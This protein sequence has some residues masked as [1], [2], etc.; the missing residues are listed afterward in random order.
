MTE[1][2]I[3]ALTILLKR[4]EIRACVFSYKLESGLKP[5][6]N[7]DAAMSPASKGLHRDIL[8]KRLD[9]AYQKYK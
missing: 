6:K 9:C 2:G 1:P 5:V 7:F 8:Q 4:S 3:E